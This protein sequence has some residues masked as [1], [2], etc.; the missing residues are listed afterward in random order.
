MRSNTYHTAPI[1]TILNPSP[2]LFRKQHPSIFIMHVPNLAS[3]LELLEISH[4]PSDRQLQFAL[5][6]YTSPPLPEAINATP[7]AY[8][9]DDTID[10]ARTLDAAGL[11]VGET[12]EVN[13]EACQMKFMNESNKNSSVGVIFYG[14]ALVDPR[15]YSPLMQM[16]SE[17]YNLPVS[18]PIYIADMAYKFG[19]CESGRLTQA[20]SAFPSVDKWIFIGHSLGGIAAFNDVWAMADRNETDS[21]GGLVLL[22]SYV[23]QDLGCGMTDFSGSEWDWLPFASVAASE[24]GVVNV[25][26][27]EDGQVFLPNDSPNF[28]DEIIEGG[29]HGGF[30]SYNYSERVTLLNQT[31]GNATITSE[32][33]QLQTATIIGDVGVM[34]MNLIKAEISKSSAPSEAPFNQNST[35]NGAE[36]DIEMP[37]DEKIDTGSSAVSSTV[38]VSCS[39]LLL[40]IA[41][42]IAH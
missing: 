1:I 33:Q 16:L 5:P 20:Q 27:F 19:T 41:I 11:C 39:M 22:A 4:H 3:L 15:G 21:I 29:N 23:R 17:E 35:N 13:A 2:Y 26:N 32:E 7:A 25:T 31:D 42:T 9:S 28:I 8:R 6:E 34:A 38:A 24:D 12:A 37:D 36:N 40:L 10:A 14:G 30:G 18:V